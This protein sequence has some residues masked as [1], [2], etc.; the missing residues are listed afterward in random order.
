M[1]THVSR[2]VR[3]S[4]VLLYIYIG[5]YIC[6][7]T[8]NHFE[9]YFRDRLTFSSIRGKTSRRIYRLALPLLSPEMLS[10][11]TKLRVFFLMYTL[12]YLSE[13]WHNYSRSILSESI[14]T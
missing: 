14:V 2:G 3:N 1:N 5:R 8:K 10:L 7:W 12:L 11:L 6:L 13:G 9:S 4:E